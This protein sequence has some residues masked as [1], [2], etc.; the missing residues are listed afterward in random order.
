MRQ[1]RPRCISDARVYL[2]HRTTT[3]SRSKKSGY[4]A[5]RNVIVVH[6]ALF[7]IEDLTFHE[8]SNEGEAAPVLHGTLVLN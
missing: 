4:L 7:K 6:A 3:P 8:K 2:R 5:P 1:T